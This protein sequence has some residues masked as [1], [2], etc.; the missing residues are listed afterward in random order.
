MAS[1]VT[2]GPSVNGVEEIDAGNSTGSTT[3]TTQ[4]PQTTTQ[5]PSHS[6]GP[7]ARTPSLS[8]FSL[9]EY[10]AKPV[11]SVDRDSNIKKIVPDELLLPNGYPDVSHPNLHR[12]YH[13]E[14]YVPAMHRHCPTH[15]FPSPAWPQRGCSTV[16]I[17]V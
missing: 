2:A 11:A 17:D 16:S 10:S 4:T 12:P 9:T 1:S 15:W 14:G 3:Q 13:R 5:T 8:S 6:D 7:L